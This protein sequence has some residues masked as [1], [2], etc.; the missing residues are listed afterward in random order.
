MLLYGCGLIV[1][2]SAQAMLVQSTH[3]GLQ[4]HPLGTPQ[5]DWTSVA[6]G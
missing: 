5:V 6:I 4:P 2:V 1:R 3:P